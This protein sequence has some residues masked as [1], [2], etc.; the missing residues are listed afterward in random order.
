MSSTERSR[1]VLVVIVVLVVAAITAAAVLSALRS[2][3]VLDPATPQGVAQSYFDAVL[4]GEESEALGLLTPEL[5]ERCDDRDFRFFFG[6]DAVRVV[7]I[8][9]EV[10]GGRAEVQVEIDRAAEPSPFD[11]DGYSTH[12]RLVMTETDAGWAISEV[13]WPF[14]CPEGS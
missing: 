13:P 11:L 8:S 4:N 7:L 14:F 2:P 9:T 5:Q 6:V 10:R 12:E 1:V 3:T